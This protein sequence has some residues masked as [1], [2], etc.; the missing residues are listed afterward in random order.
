MSSRALLLAAIRRGDPGALTALVRAGADIHAPGPWGATVLLDAAVQGE[1]DCGRVLL[2]A[3]ASTEV[4][5]PRTGATAL[6]EAARFGCTGFV[7]LLLEHG[8]DRSAVDVDGHNARTLAL[9]NDHV[10]TAELLAAAGVP[11][12][13]EFARDIAETRAAI[14]AAAAQL[15]GDRRA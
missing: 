1:V 15:A 8:A 7:Q 3:G 10:P 13:P 12:Q 4:P 9:L 2:D 11:R 14:R 5:D 6:L